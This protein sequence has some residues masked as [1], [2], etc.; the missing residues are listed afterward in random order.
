MA[1]RVKDLAL[2]LL[3]L[4]FDPWPGNDPRPQ[5][6]GKERVNAPWIV[7]GLRLISRVLKK[8]VLTV[9][10][11]VLIAFLEEIFGSPYSAF[12]DDVT[13]LFLKEM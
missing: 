10:A 5:K 13:Q 2:A 6:K 11:N 1:Q 9:F 8:F 7:A 12:S 3:W 4:R